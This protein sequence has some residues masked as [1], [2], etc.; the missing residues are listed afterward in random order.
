MLRNPGHHGNQQTTGI[1]PA[2]LSI[3]EIYWKDVGE[4]IEFPRGFEKRTQKIS[5]N[6][7]TPVGQERSENHATAPLLSHG[8][9]RGWP[10]TRK[11]PLVPWCRLPPGYG[12]GHCLFHLDQLSV[13][14]SLILGHELGVGRFSGEGKDYP[15]QYSGLENSMNCIFHGVTKSHTRL[16]DF[17]FHLQFKPRHKASYLPNPPTHSNWQ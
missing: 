3:K 9:H 14:L 8:S 2:G 11:W 10:W 5:R 1:T 7:R 13:N 17:H 15:L 6:R 4:H 12:P 16:S